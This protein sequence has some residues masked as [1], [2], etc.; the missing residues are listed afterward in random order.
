MILGAFLGGM[1]VAAVLAPPL[2]GADH[3]D[4]ASAPEVR[5]G[6]VETGQLEPG[7]RDCVH[8]WSV[9][10]RAGDELVVRVTS[11][12]ADTGFFFARGDLSQVTSFPD[13]KGTMVFRKEVV[14]AG[15]HLLGV[16]PADATCS[17]PVPY[18]L[19]V[20]VRRHVPLVASVSRPRPGRVRVV[21]RFAKPG[22][23]IRIA[24]AAPGRALARTVRVGPRG[25]ATV[26]FMP[27]P[28]RYRVL[29]AYAGDATTR[30]AQGS[31]AVLVR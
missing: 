7:T 23:S 20:A 28:G 1:A 13:F 4:P 22:A 12:S 29:V 16:V 27:R 8:Y 6:V 31:L 30:P 15:R 26:L 24:L 11:A 2:L 21:V 3:A 14:T 10:V 17:Q 5:V 18:E 9:R 19:Q 25:R